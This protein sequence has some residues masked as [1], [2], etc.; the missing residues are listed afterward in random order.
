MPRATALRTHGMEKAVAAWPSAH[1]LD[2]SD[3]YCEP[4]VCRPVIGN[5]VVYRDTGHLTAAF[6][7]TLAPFLGEDLAAI[8]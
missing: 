6:A 1:L 2:F 3:L 5:V 4:E 8:G 7:K